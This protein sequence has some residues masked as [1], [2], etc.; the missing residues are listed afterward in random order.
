MKKF[1]TGC[2]LFSGL[3][4]ALLCSGCQG[5]AVHSLA[6][7][8]GGRRVSADSERVQ[9][10]FEFNDIRS[11]RAMNSVIVHYAQDSVASVRA[12]APAE[13][14]DVAVVRMAPD[15]ELQVEL[16]S[17]NKFRFRNDSERLHVY[18]NAPGLSAINAF[19]GSQ[20][21]CTTPLTLT[22]ALDII[23]G[24][25][26]SIDFGDLYAGCVKAVSTSGASISFSTVRSDMLDLY[27]STGSSIDADSVVC[28]F[29]ELVAETG[30]SI[31]AAGEAE[32]G[33]VSAMTGGST[34]ARRLHIKKGELQAFTGGSVKAYVDEVTRKEISGG[35]SVKNKE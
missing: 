4:L 23:T 34:N 26:A 13:V 35:G 31:R 18:V 14:M 20:V 11:L 5:S 30:A 19:S 6:S 7:A 29:A 28:R 16:E 15:G 33:E 25:G 24:S 10:T 27:A 32:S 21:D 3:T 8:F 1:I 2:V 9:K 12:E 17:N 22:G